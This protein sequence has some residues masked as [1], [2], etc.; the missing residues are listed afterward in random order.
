MVD[1][2]VS[3]QWSRRSVSFVHGRLLGSVTVFSEWLPC[4][5][6]PLTPQIQEKTIGRARD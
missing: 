2:H 5:V 1:N 6:D 3:L 4:N